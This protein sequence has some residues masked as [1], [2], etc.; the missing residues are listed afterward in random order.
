LASGNG[1]RVKHARANELAGLRIVNDRMQRRGIAVEHRDH[2]AVGGDGDGVAENCLEP[3]T[4]QRQQPCKRPVGAPF[5]EQMKGEEQRVFADLRA[6]GRD[7]P[8]D[9]LQHHG[10]IASR[11]ALIAS[12]GRR[13]RSF[14]ASR[15]CSGSMATCVWRAI[16]DRIAAQHYAKCQ[17]ALSQNK[18]S[19][20]FE[21]VVTLVQPSAAR[22]RANFLHPM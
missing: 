16:V 2:H 18:G 1:E 6:A 19:D 20:G 17:V 8:L 3:V 5:A 11:A 4:R 21:S 12:T 10:T 14:N 7:V 22:A 13:S 15:I 9:V